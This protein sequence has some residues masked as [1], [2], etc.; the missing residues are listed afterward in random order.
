MFHKLESLLKRTKHRI[1]ATLTLTTLV[2]VLILTTTAAVGQAAAT[3]MSALMTTVNTTL[4]ALLTQTQTSEKAIADTVQTTTHP[5]Q[6]IGTMH[7]YVGNS[8]QRYRAYSLQ[9]STFN[10]VSSTTSQVSQLQ[11]TARGGSGAIDSGYYAVF[12]NKLPQSTSV[13]A[14]LGQQTDVTDALALQS[15]SRAATISSTSST[16]IQ[17][18]NQVEDQILQSAPGNSDLITAHA[19]AL[20]LQNMATDHQILAE[21]IRIE[22]GSLADEAYKR[23]Q[24]L[25]VMVTGK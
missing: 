15:L 19:L 2:L 9:I 5:L 3:V 23:K 10:P 16:S 14:S 8:I 13:P 11:N 4:A 7:S 18:A 24:A 17:Q 21:T 25:N 12:G 22:A 20:Q 6:Q 1:V